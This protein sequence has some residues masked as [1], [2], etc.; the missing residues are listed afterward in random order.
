MSERDR[1]IVFVPFF[2]SVFLFLLPGGGGGWCGLG[3]GEETRTGF[4]SNSPGAMSLSIHCA[5]RMEFWVAPPGTYWTSGLS[6]SSCAEGRE[7]ERKRERERERDD[8]VFFFQE[9]KGLKRQRS[10]RM[11]DRCRSIDGRANISPLPQFVLFSSNENV[12]SHLE[13]RDVLFLSED[14]VGH[15]DLFGVVFA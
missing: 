14:L 3:R 1:T 7:R 13:H 12:I 11:R 9:K 2:C 4:P 15:L 5:T 10:V 8:F 6:A